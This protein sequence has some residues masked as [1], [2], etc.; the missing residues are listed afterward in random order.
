[1]NIIESRSNGRYYLGD[2]EQGRAEAM[3]YQTR[4][5]EGVVGDLYVVKLYGPNDELTDFGA[6][7]TIQDAWRY[8]LGQALGSE[9]D[10]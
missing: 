5:T 2:L 1:M 7:P 3:R 6:G 9:E 4:W 8:A 10:E